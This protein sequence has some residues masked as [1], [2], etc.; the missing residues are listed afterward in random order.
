MNKGISMEKSILDDLTFEELENNYFE[1]E[2]KD[3]SKV[4]EQKYLFSGKD[5]NKICDERYCR[6]YETCARRINFAMK[7]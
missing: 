4:P 6:Y 2:C 5:A 1:K 7:K 3:S